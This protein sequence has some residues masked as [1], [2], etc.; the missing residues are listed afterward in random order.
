M[1]KANIE[2]T[3]FIDSEK[4]A[5][6]PTI[7]KLLS[8][9]VLSRNSGLLSLEEE[10]KNG[11]DAFLK[12]AIAMVTDAAEPKLI[13]N[14]LR[15]TIETDKSKSAELLSRL[16]IVQGV[17]SIA[18]GEPTQEV[19]LKLSKLMGDE[20]AASINELAHAEELTYTEKAANESDNEPFD[21]DLTDEIGKLLADKYPDTDWHSFYGETDIIRSM[22]EEA[23]LAN[24]LPKVSPAREG[25]LYMSILM[26]AAMSLP[27]K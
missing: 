5:C 11:Q 26:A 27:Y 24:M 9:S 8:F 13:E 2:V 14:T 12:A 3:Q 6:M 19:A 1:K 23:G 21:S 4:E 17:L 16:L 25:D 20:Y 15:E 10:L 22:V 7:Q 18:A